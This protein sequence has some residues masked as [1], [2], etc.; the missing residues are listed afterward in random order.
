MFIGKDIHS[1]TSPQL[2]I[3]MPSNHDAMLASLQDSKCCVADHLFEKEDSFHMTFLVGHQ[4]AD[5]SMW[6]E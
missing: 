3:T 4:P 1:I 2:N 5:V 6:E